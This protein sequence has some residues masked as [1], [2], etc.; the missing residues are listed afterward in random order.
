MFGIPLPSGSGGPN[1]SAPLNPANLSAI[2]GLVFIFAIVWIVFSIAWAL[3][4]FFSVQLVMDKNLGAIEA[5]STS[6]KAAFSNAGGAIVLM[7]LC[8]LVIILGALAVCLGLFVAV[9][10]TWVATAVAYR[11]VFPRP[12]E[13]TWHTPPPPTAYGTSFGQGM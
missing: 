5:I 13:T 7:I 12:V 3:V 2:T 9:P 10:V 1:A 8:G 11:A 6:A 4:F